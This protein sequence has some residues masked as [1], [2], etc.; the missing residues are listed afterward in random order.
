MVPQGAKTQHVFMHKTR[1]TSTF[2]FWVWHV[3]KVHHFFHE[4]PAQNSALEL[5]AGKYPSQCRAILVPVVITPLLFG[6]SIPPNSKRGG[7]CARNI[8]RSRDK[9]MFGGL[10]VCNTV[11][12]LLWQVALSRK[13]IRS[14]TVKLTEARGKLR[15]HLLLR[16]FRFCR[17]GKQIRGGQAKYRAGYEQTGLGR[18]GWQAERR[19]GTTRTC[20]RYFYVRYGYRNNNKHASRLSRSM[21]LVPLG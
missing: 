6:L 17:F 11:G 21:L 2:S 8:S 16:A 7:G 3:E 20:T 12:T 4:F 15:A 13:C 5:P 19:W 14:Q 10:S 1:H 9:N 18:R